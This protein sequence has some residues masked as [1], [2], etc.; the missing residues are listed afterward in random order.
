MPCRPCERGIFLF[1]Y[2]RQV[3]Y[4]SK[5]KYSMKEIDYVREI[6]LIYVNKIGQIFL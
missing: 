1:I 2:V 6:F 3:R 5:V 4:F